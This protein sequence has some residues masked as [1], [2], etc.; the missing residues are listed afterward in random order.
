ML[1]EPDTTVLEPGITEE[2]E[3][4]TPVSGKGKKKDWGSNVGT[5]EP[6]TRTKRPRVKA[7]GTDP[8]HPTD[9][10]ARNSPEAAEW[11]KARERSEIN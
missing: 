5:R 1:P 10:Q 9:G 11:A 7:V 4:D 2:Q 6:S 8:D 3:M